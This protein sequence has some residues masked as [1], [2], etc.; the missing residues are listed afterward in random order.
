M[1]MVRSL[2]WAD[3]AKETLFGLA[4]MPPPILLSLAR[5]SAE[6]FD[7]C[8][9]GNTGTGGFVLSVEGLAGGLFRLLLRSVEADGFESVENR[10]A[11]GFVTVLFVVV[12]LAPRSMIRDLFVEIEDTR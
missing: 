11:T 3:G 9:L 12:G 1:E 5:S 2:L 7:A 4:P 8:F 10:G 6:I